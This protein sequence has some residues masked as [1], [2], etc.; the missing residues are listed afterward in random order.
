MPKNICDIVLEIEKE[1]ISWLTFI[2]EH[3][4]L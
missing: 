1:I 4:D 2:K 3:L